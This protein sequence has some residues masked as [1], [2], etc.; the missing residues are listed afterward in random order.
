V[1]EY[2]LVRSLLERVEREALAHDARSVH[3]L[4]VRI[5]PLAGVDPELFGE[6]YR[7]CRPGTRCEEAELVLTTEHVDWRCSVC[8]GAIPAG[9]VLVCPG[10]GWPAR[11]AGGD[12]IV[13]E[14]IEMEVTRHV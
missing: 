12:G 11:L 3:R 14:R 9:A 6:A 2:G 7:L 13:L 8:D 10:C 4:T 5:G 1:H